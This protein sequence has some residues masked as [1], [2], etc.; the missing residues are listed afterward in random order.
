MGIVESLY[1]G[2]GHECR[3]P[4]E[5]R[6]TMF[7]PKIMALMNLSTIYADEEMLKK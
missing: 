5:I 4:I 1:Q 2:F 6:S 3:F 7:G